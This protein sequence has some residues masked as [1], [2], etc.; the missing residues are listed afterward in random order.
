[1][2]NRSS[3]SIFTYLIFLAFGVSLLGLGANLMHLQTLMNRPDDNDLTHPILRGG[4][5]HSRA[6]LL[7]DLQ[8]EEQVFT[9]IL[10]ESVVHLEECSSRAVITTTLPEK[11]LRKLGRFGFMNA[12]NN[13]LPMLSTTASNSKCYNAPSTAC[14]VTKYSMIVVTNGTNLRTLF[15]NLLSWL[16]YANVAQ[17]VI[18][19]P[20]AANA[21]LGEDAKYGQRILAWNADSSHKI[22]VQ[23]STSL[24]TADYSRLLQEDDSNSDAVTWIN[25]DVVDKGNHRGLDAGLELWKRHANGVVASRGWKVST[26]SNN[27]RRLQQLSN[28]TTSSISTPAFCK[29]DRITATSVGDDDD[30]S[31]PNLNGMIVHRNYLCFLAHPV[32]KN[33]HRFTNNNL[34][35]E[36]LAVAMLLQQ[37][38][39]QLPRLFPTKVRAERT[40][41]KRKLTRDAALQSSPTGA[42]SPSILPMFSSGGMRRLFEEEERN[43]EEDAAEDA[44]TSNSRR[45]LEVMNEDLDVDFVTAVAG[46]FG[47]LPTKSIGWCDGCADET[48]SMEEVPINLIP[49][50][51]DTC[52]KAT[53]I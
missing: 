35:E 36:R 40:P 50:M 23:V 53:I 6:L 41:E 1:M 7:Q 28:T 49:W 21:T 29:D 37:V 33:L 19:I 42:S 5:Q 14:H 22:S 39:G 25:G 12:L 38:S 34:D 31:I 51:S 13:D 9:R 30:I 17:L 47:S 10:K 20:P 48:K 45:L 3:T 18:V 52:S 2:M 43:V 27:Q 16:T 44:L 11:S 46:F 15:L 26:L 24:W 8:T 32:L 4:G